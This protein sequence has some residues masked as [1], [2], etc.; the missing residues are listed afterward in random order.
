[1][2]LRLHDDAYLAHTENGSYLVT[3]RGRS[4]VAGPSFARW[5]EALTPRLDGRLTEAE[6]TARFPGTHTAAVRAVLGQLRD[7][8]ALIEE[9]S[10]P[11]S[12][13]AAVRDRFAAELSYLAAYGDDAVTAFGRFR[14]LSVTVLADDAWGSVIEEHLRAAGALRVDLRGPVAG[15]PAD[16]V[17]GRDL[18]IAVCVD[19]SAAR[20]LAARCAE[21]KVALA[22]LLH[23]GTDVWLPAI[24]DP[25]PGQGDPL[26]SAR[27][28]SVLDRLPGPRPPVALTGTH[29]AVV[30]ASAVRSV[31]RW[32]TGTDDP[33]QAGKVARLGPD[34]VPDRQ[35]C[36]AHP[37][38]LP[39]PPGD[40]ES[41][42]ERITALRDRPA[43]TDREFSETA[44]R[45][46]DETFGLFRYRPDDSTAQSPVHVAEAQVRDPRFD[47][48]WDRAAVVRAVAFDY[49]TAR[50]E[51]ARRA[52]TRYAERFVDP[53][54][55]VGASGA[56]LV[57]G[58]TGPAE[59]RAALAAGAPGGLVAGYDLV[60][61]RV[62][63]IPAA[64]VFARR[65]Q[66]HD[67]SGDATAAG[68]GA[69]WTPALT[70]ALA[71]H[72]WRDPA[73][74][75]DLPGRPV[76]VDPT[77]LD[78][79]GRRCARILEELGELPEVYD[80]RG[81]HGMTVLSFRR[82]EHIL[83]RVAGSAGEAW[84]EGLTETL[85]AV[86]RWVHGERPRPPRATAPPRRP[87]DEVVADAG[88]LD[89][90]A[91]VAGLAATG[92]SV[93]VVALDHD[94]AVATLLPH[95]LKVVLR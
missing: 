84:T 45:A 9:P 29:R 13:D 34:L 17:A 22:V 26:A 77:T 3:P 31:F 6:L 76:Q 86:Q 19:A 42:R 56:P 81:R 61:D 70:R 44:I 60:R 73:L 50:I 82:G 63:R 53:R 68:F 4:W 65:G 25:D 49:A 55:L 47:H 38:H 2:R 5:I 59:L 20:R 43:V 18:A 64:A 93:V 21:Q 14:D 89:L 33:A 30:A 46:A 39:V 75:G 15:D 23:D 62:V 91:A 87:A 51:A 24:A 74:L 69:S 41:V 92:R 27:V 54:R 7:A 37:Y 1:M 67:P 90:D 10:A 8:G 32:A 36:L 79:V 12:L 48:G 83:A 88:A 71:A 94:P 52:L 58:D 80:H 16:A 66:S 78:E 28:G 72:W 35:H 85:F 95:A 57:P 40:D 11:P